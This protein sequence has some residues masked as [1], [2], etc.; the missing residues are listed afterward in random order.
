MTIITL[1][2][3][4]PERARMELAGADN[5]LSSFTGSSVVVES[6]EFLWV[7]E[8]AIK[9]QSDSE[10]RAWKSAVAQLSR[11]SN[12]FRYT[13]PEYTGNSAGYSG[14]A[15]VVKGAGQLGLT[16][17]ADGVTASA[18]IAKEGD[19]IEAG[20]ELKVLTADADSDIGG[21]VT[22]SIFPPFRNSPADNSTIEIDAPAAT[23]R[24]VRPSAG[25]DVSSPLRHDFQIQAIEAF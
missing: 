14:A 18:A 6:V 10:A 22:F 3:T 23:F 2:A 9:R 20:G 11:L 21:N 19:Y 13:P 1:P 24:M 5:P 4:E 25:W 17:N 16:L 15:P 8:F 7:L 12:T